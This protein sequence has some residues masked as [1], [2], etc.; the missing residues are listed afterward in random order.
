MSLRGSGFGGKQ[1]VRGGAQAAVSG[2]ELFGVRPSAGQ[3]RQSDDL[4]W[5]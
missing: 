4:I 1:R 5:P 2:D 3:P